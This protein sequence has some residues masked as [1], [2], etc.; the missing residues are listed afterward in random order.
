MTARG[1]L[2]IAPTH[3]YGRYLIL[4]AHKGSAHAGGPAFAGSQDGGGGLFFPLGAAVGGAG[5]AVPGLDADKVGL[6]GL[7]PDQGLGEAGNPADHGTAGVLLIDTQGVG[8]QIT[9]Q[10][11][12]RLDPIGRN[13]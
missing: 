1:R 4:S 7:A 9:P 10:S 5:Q 12:H 13:L 8:L 6:A 2:I 11:C 3:S